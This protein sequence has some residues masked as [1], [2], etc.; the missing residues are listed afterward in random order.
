MSG[1]Q[2][3][4]KGMF[5]THKGDSCPYSF[6]VTNCDKCEWNK[7]KLT[8]IRQV[9]EKY[10]LLHR[11][12]YVAINKAEI[13]ILQIIAQQRNEFLDEIAKAEMRNYNYHLFDMVEKE[14]AYSEGLER[15]KKIIMGEGE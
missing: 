2:E 9:L 10:F 1:K 8:E 5:C 14:Q 4:K 6:L 11:G 13:E 12:E 3:P 15:A 7:T